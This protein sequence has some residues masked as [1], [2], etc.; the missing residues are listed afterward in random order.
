MRVSVSYLRPWK[1]GEGW[2]ALTLAMEVFEEDVPE[3]RKV[4]G[5]QEQCDFEPGAIRLTSNP[6]YII[7]NQCMYEQC[8]P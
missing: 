1:G 3:L 6:E 2:F 4:P 5:H 8:N 7:Q